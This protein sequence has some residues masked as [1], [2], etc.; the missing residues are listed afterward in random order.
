MP[1]CL[2]ALRNILTVTLCRRAISLAL[3]EPDEIRR[4]LDLGAHGIYTDFDL[5]LVE[6]ID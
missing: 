3:N 2:I 1:Q 4:A 5:S 6:P